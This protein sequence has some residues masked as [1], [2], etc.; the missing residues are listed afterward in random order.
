[1]KQRSRKLAGLCITAAFIATANTT[2][3][4]ARESKDQVVKK[5]QA[6]EQKQ[7][8]DERD[9]AVHIGAAAAA[10]EVAE[11]KVEEYAEMAAAGEEAACG[12]A[13]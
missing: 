6:I 8:A 2:T 7:D 10:I 3:A 9:Q 4:V 12:S 13:G 5:E 11:Q 1:M